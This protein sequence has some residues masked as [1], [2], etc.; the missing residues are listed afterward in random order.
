[1]AMMSRIGEIW[2]RFWFPPVPLRRL[3]LYRVAVAAFCFLDVAFLTAGNRDFA[4]TPAFFFSPTRSLRLLGLPVPREPWVTSLRLLLLLAL[5][6]LL[7]GLGGRIVPWLSALLYTWWT[8]LPLLFGDMSHGRIPVIFSLFVLAIGPSMDS[9]TIRRDGRSAAISSPAAGW[10]LRVIQFLLVSAY[11]V[12]AA[13][14]L[15]Y[16]GLGWAGGRA[17][18]SALLRPEA[19]EL[20]RAMLHV[21][22]LLVAASISLMLFEGLAFLAFMRGRPRDVWMGSGILFH[23][24]TYATFG[25]DFMPWTLA[26]LAFYDLEVAADRLSSLRPAVSATS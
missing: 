23:G 19:T 18:S 11:I 26:Y 20:G 13:A 6:L 10:A 4:D 9:C 5:A 17:L 2:N 8:A 12:A 25:L 24:I 1:M 14:K 3:G 22:G 16:S 15:R 21:D 7:V